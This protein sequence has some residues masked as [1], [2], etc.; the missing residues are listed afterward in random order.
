MEKLN[1]SGKIVFIIVVILF[2]LSIIINLNISE[3]RMEIDKLIMKIGT[4][5]EKVNTLSYLIALENPNYTITCTANNR[6]ILEE[7]D[8]LILNP[9]DCSY[10]LEFIR[11]AEVLEALG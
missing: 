7:G 6:I 10:H 5:S 9:Q 1:L 4:T 11:N 3:N 8:N 2:L